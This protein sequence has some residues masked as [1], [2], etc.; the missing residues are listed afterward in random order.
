[1]DNMKYSSGCGSFRVRLLIAIFLCN[2][3]L[4]GPLSAAPP[5]TWKSL[6]SDHSFDAWREDHRGWKIAGDVALNPADPSRLVNKPGNGVLVSDGDA[7][8]LESRDDYQDVDLRLEFMIPKHSNAG[9]KLE[10]RYEIQILDTYGI[11]VK[12]LTGDSCGGIYPRAE[13]KPDYHHI[14]RGVPPRVNAARP[15]GEWQSLE[16]E[17]V[18]PRF[19]TA[20]KKSSNAEFVRVVLNGKVIHENVAVSAPT[21]AA[22]RLVKEVPRGPLLLQGDHGRVAFRNIQVRPHE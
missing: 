2:V 5:A 17:F 4:T 13:E 6:S 1:M 16:I 12:E 22:W 7:S 19:D 11:N 3:I 20:G 10:G 14:D 18:A 8:N 9:V 21:G 15:T